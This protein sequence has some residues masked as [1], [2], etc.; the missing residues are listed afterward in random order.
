MF[1]YSGDKLG[2]VELSEQGIPED[3]VASSLQ[4]LGGGPQPA[5]VWAGYSL[6][7]KPFHIKAGLPS[8]GN[9]TE[10][11]RCDNRIGRPQWLHATQ[12]KGAVSSV[13]WSSGAAAEA[14][15]VQCFDEECRD[16]LEAPDASDSPNCSPALINT[17]VFLDV[18]YLAHGVWASSNGDENAHT[19]AAF[20]Q[21]DE[22][23]RNLVVGVTRGTPDP[24]RHRLLDAMPPI[25]TLSTSSPENVALSLQPYS[26]KTE[27]AVVGISWIERGKIARLSGLD[28]CLEP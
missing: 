14:T 24:N 21:D 28:L 25:Q 1:A 16:L 17:R 20:V 19:V 27:R 9:Y 18:N 15:R 26:P 13:A 2:N 23:S 3:L 5:A 10:L 22:T 4:A 7:S 8:L 6:E 11:A 12:V